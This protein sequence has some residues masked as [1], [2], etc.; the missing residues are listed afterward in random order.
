M[1]EIGAEACNTNPQHVFHQRPP[2]GSE[3][4]YPSTLG[5]ALRLPLRD[6][7]DGEELWVTNRSTESMGVSEVDWQCH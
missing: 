4:H 2:P 5:H 7:P 3:F 6:V 1:I